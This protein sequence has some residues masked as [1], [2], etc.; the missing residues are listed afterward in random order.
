MAGLNQTG[1]NKVTKWLLIPGGIDWSAHIKTVECWQ[2]TLK[3]Y[4]SHNMAFVRLLD[5]AVCLLSMGVLEP[6][7]CS[8]SN[9]TVC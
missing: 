9:K 6:M 8:P 5:K 3:R 7:Q 1:L 4:L 2:S